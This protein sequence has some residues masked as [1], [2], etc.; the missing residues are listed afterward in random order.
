M[1]MSAT[2]VTKASFTVNMASVVS[3]E[4]ERN[5][6]FDGRIMD[7][8]A[9]PTAVF[10]LTS[11]IKLAPVPAEGTVGEFPAAGKLAMHGVTKVVDFTGHDRAHRERHLRA[12][13]HP[14]CLRR[15][16]HLEPERRRFRHH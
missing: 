8:S 5:A 14:H 11:P 2:S 16:G 15:L 13:R 9:Y 12:R 7:V 3:D 10:V 4:S 1:T 6:E